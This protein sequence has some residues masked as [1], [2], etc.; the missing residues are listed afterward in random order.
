MLSGG[1]KWR[2]VWT[3]AKSLN[4]KLHKTNLFKFINFYKLKIFLQKVKGFIKSKF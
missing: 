3:D 2:E 4:F 1:Q